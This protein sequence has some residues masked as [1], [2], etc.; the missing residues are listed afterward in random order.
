MIPGQ[1]FI[2]NRVGRMG[3]MH[4]YHSVTVEG[5]KK[6]DLILC[7]NH[8]N[9]LKHYL[10]EHHQCDQYKQVYSCKAYYL[11]HT[12]MHTYIGVS[13]L[14]VFSNAN[15]T[16]NLECG[17]RANSQNTDIAHQSF[18]TSLLYAM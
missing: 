7:R 18:C 1:Y 14:H 8:F 2:G 13:V 16:N 11:I 17:K 10:N 5:Q 4:Q 12:C 15:S 9:F 6:S 3:Y